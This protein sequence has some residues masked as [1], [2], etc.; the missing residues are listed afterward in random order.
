[1][2]SKDA[3]GVESHHLFRYLFKYLEQMSEKK[4]KENSY[5]NSRGFFPVLHVSQHEDW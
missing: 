5:A 2:Q 4:K 3:D 1:M